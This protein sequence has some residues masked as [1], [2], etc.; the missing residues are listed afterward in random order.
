MNGCTFRLPNHGFD[1]CLTIK[2]NNITDLFYRH[3]INIQEYIEDNDNELNEK[4]YE[5]YLFIKDHNK[6]F[7]VEIVKEKIEKF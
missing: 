1:F 6:D 4:S 3:P 7:E 2:D 5:I